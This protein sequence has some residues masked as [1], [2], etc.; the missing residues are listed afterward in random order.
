MWGLES[1]TYRIRITSYSASE[2]ASTAMH[3]IDF[4][5]IGLGPGAGG[6]GY[7]KDKF[8][9]FHWKNKPGK[10][11][12]IPLKDEFQSF[13][14]RLNEAQEEARVEDIDKFAATDNKSTLTAAR[15]NDMLHLMQTST[16]G[17]LRGT[18]E[19]EVEHM[20]DV[21]RN[22]VIKAK[23]FQQLE[24][25]YNHWK[26]GTIQSGT[27]VPMNG[28]FAE[29]VW[30]YLRS[31]GF[32]PQAAAG[33]IGNMVAECGTPNTTD[34][35]PTAIGYTPYFSYG[36]CQWT[37]DFGTGSY[38]GQDIWYA[39]FEDQLRFLNNTMQ[40]VME[41]RCLGSYN[42][43]KNATNIQQATHDFQWCYEYGGSGTDW[44]RY[45]NAIIAYNKFKNRPLWTPSTGGSGN[46]DGIATG[47][48]GWPFANGGGSITQY[49]TWN[50]VGGH[51]GVDI[52]TT[53]GYGAGS[54]VLAV[55]GGTVVSAGWGVSHGTYGNEVNI[56]HGNGLYTR[57]A[58]LYQINVSVGQNVSKGQIIGIEGNTGNSD[59]TH[60]H[61]EVH[62]GIPNGQRYNPMNYLHRYG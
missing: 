56:S 4:S 24:D 23:H 5:S 19:D 27:D 1:S 54:P 58:H 30:D 7:F 41:E 39:S 11:V 43:L 15:F 17:D 62:A 25:L 31:L 46:G 48:M 50:G 18:S 3:Y 51:L 44:Q 36:L 22:D 61:F 29:R 52:S 10:D 57:Y 34:L 38:R 20:E 14:D 6:G 26:Y 32:T 33:I 37:A 42:R 21:S 9:E 16:E 8:G 45:Q 12:L 2:L 49:F 55:D 40:G 28:S 13:C 53:S 47:T 60:L 59:G 35:N